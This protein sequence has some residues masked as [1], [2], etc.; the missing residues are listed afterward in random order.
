MA[1]NATAEIQNANNYPY[2]RLFT[3][4]QT[5]ASIQQLELITVEQNWSIANNATVGGSPWTYFSALCWFW[6]VEM[7]NTLNY[8]VGLITSAVGGSAIRSWLPFNSIS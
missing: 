5:S 1:M 7:Y 3:S 6:G 2:I 8:P 4:T